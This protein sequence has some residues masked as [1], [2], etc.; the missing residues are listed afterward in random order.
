MLCFNL[1]EVF[2][3]NLLRVMGKVR[4]KIKDGGC[5]P[6]G[7]LIGYLCHEA[8]YEPDR[9]NKRLIP[10]RTSVRPLRNKRA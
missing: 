9:C 8:G 6:V 2:P 4:I 10:P 5:L 1:I 7:S 3:K